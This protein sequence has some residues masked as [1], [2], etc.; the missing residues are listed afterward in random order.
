M[1]GIYWLQVEVCGDNYLPVPY[2]SDSLKH[3][4]MLL[5]LVVKMTPIRQVPVSRNIFS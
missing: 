5:M 2:G 3:T 1:V 4:A